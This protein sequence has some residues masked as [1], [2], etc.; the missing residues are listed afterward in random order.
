M[1]ALFLGTLW[2]LLLPS[3]NQSIY[4]HRQESSTTT[5]PNSANAVKRK[6]KTAYILLWQ[7]LVQAYT[8]IYVIKWSFWW[9]FSTC[10]YLQ[11]VSYSQAIWQTAVEKDAPI[12]N[13]AVEAMYTII[14]KYF[15]T[16]YQ[17]NRQKM[18]KNGHKSRRRNFGDI[19]KF[20]SLG[21]PGHR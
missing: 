21:I 8:N 9:A 11:I 19:S 12:Y 5:A 20:H 16:F 17:V 18:G 15:Y 7:H 10:G 13:G 4:F 1:I 6:F 14:S 3:V 2:V